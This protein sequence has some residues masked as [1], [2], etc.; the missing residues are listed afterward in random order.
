MS[1]F[2]TTYADD[3]R[4]ALSDWTIN[5]RSGKAVTDLHLLLANRAQNDLWM[6][7]PWSNLSKSVDITLNNSSQYTI[8]ADVGRIIDVGD[9]VSGVPHSW[10]YEGDDE[11]YGYTIDAG[12]T[13]SAG[14]ARVM[15]FNFNVGST[16]KMRYVKVLEDF[17]GVGTE[18]SYFPANLIIAY[19]QMINSN[20][21]GNDKEYQL[22]KMQFED[23][24]R[25]FLNSTQ[26][27][28]ANTGPAL[29]DR[30]GNKVVSQGF[31]L[32]GDSQRNTS[33]YPN[34]YLRPGR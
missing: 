32:G 29:N 20:S 5:S 16:L 3:I 9:Y 14:F 4:P 2:T 33:P 26:Y 15:T 22:I 17:T 25:D 10:Y 24:Y 11:T 27:I 13:K 34:T 23:I 31:S 28:N 30:A 8:P 21:K 12:F 18:Y 6:K 19:A 7:K 1:I